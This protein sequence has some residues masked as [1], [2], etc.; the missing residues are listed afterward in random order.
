MNIKKIND[1]INAKKTI[2]FTHLHPT[3]YC[4]TSSFYN[5]Y[6]KKYL[7]ND[8]NVKLQ[9]IVN[10]HNA[11]YKYNPYQLFEINNSFIFQ[12]SWKY[13]RNLE[14]FSFDKLYLRAGKETARLH[15]FFDKY[16][17]NACMYP[18]IYNMNFFQQIIELIELM[19]DCNIVSRSTVNKLSESIFRAL[20]NLQQKN[21]G[22]VH[23]DIH[24]NNFVTDGENVYL[25]DFDMVGYGNRLFDF[26]V[27]FF[28]IYQRISF[29]ALYI[30]GYLSQ[31][32]IKF[33]WQEF[34]Q[35]C[36]LTRVLCICSNLNKHSNYKWLPSYIEN[37]INF[38]DSMSSTPPSIIRNFFY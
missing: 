10:I 1:F 13:C 32:K 8:I 37:T 22:G 23:G 21:I 29:F 15:I 5:G 30:E 14:E 34:K 4:Q 3:F 9:K 11:F 19:S 28:S 7:G 36:L 20:R 17:T 38:V 24:T 27:F 6:L 18:T 35:V 12:S 26:S 16:F 2:E 25:I 33:S 31:K